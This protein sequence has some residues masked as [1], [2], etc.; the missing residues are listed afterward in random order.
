MRCRL[1]S[2]MCSGSGVAGV[3]GGAGD[4]AAEALVAGPADDGAAAFARC[5]GDK[6]DADLRGELIVGGEPL[7]EL[8]A[9]GQELRRAQALRAREAHAPAVG[10]AGNSMRDGG[11]SDLTS[12]FCLAGQSGWSCPLVPDQLGWRAAPTA[13][14]LGEEGGQALF[15][16]LAGTVVGGQATGEGGRD[17]VAVLGGASERAEAKAVGA[18]N[19][20][21]QEGIGRALLLPTAL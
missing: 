4:G 15:A 9:F 14:V 6:T 5:A 1:S 2:S 3:V 7:T 11:L 13:G 19:F 10:Q 21:Q 20:R 12:G 8:A 17:R 18:Q 16:Q